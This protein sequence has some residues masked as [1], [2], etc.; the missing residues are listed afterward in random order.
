LSWLTRRR[1]DAAREL[2]E[3]TDTSVEQ[4]GVLVGLPAATTFRE[5]F[6]TVA[7]VTPSAYRAAFRAR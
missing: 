6:R 5:R 7:G 2:L 3:T 4:V 1:V